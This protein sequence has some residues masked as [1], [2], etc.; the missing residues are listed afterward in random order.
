MTRSC[1]WHL[2]FSGTASIL[3]L[4]YGDVLGLDSFPRKKKRENETPENITFPVF[5]DSR[6][7]FHN[8]VV[9]SVNTGDHDMAHTITTLENVTNV[10]FSAGLDLV[11]SSCR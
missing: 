5:A 3:Q 9:P 8:L 10:P 1:G 4:D 7:G 6:R 11:P 2:H